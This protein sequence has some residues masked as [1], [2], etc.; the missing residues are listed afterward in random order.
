MIV[1]QH[2]FIRVRATGIAQLL[3]FCR[4]KGYRVI[5][6]WPLAGNVYRV[7]AMRAN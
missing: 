6:Y 3:A 7:K 1:G 5:G 2:E 4:A